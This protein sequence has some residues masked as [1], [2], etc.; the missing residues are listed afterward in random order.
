MQN[1]LVNVI[2]LFRQQ[3][4]VFSCDIK[5][6]Y[7]QILVHEEDQSYQCIV[8]RENPSEEL[9][10]NH[11]GSTYGVTSAPYLAIRTLVQLAED[12]GHYH[13]AAAQALLHN[14]F[15]DD[16]VA[17]GDTIESAITLRSE[18]VQLLLRGQFVLRKWAANDSRLLA[19]IPLDHLLSSDTQ[20][21]NV[22]GI[23]WDLSS[24]Q[25]TINVSTQALSRPSGSLVHSERTI[26]ATIARI[27]DPCGWISP[28]LLLAK[29]F[30]QS[31]WLHLLEWDSIL[32]WD[33]AAPWDKLLKSLLSSPPFSIP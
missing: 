17:G 5:Q 21:L 15:V 18:L 7:S 33:L 4:F 6:A 26:I 16:I 28:V 25:F 24:D 22:L 14:A 30:L 27:Y 1:L 31:L 12:D 8:W 9:Q 11:L 32:P 13:P 19:N 10:V 29:S 3:R 2:S 23:P 20:S